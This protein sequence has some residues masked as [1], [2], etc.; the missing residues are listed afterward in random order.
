LATHFFYLSFARFLDHAA[1]ELGVET[2]TPAFV[3]SLQRF[4]TPSYKALLTFASRV[5]TNA[6]LTA[7]LQSQKGGERIR[8]ACRLAMSEVA[9]SIGDGR[10]RETIEA[11]RAIREA[12]GPAVEEWALNP[13]S[14]PD[15]QRFES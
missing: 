1:R 6:P 12:L 5:L 11:L 7:A 14:L 15:E 4:A 9:Q 3:D 13:L 8:D 10:E 2:S